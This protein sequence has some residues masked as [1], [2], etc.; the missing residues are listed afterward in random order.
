MK[1]HAKKTTITLVRPAQPEPRQRQDSTEKASISQCKPEPGQYQDS[2]EFAS[3][4]LAEAEPTALATPAPAKK[5]ARLIISQAAQTIAAQLREDRPMVHAQ[6]QRIINTVGKDRAQ[7]L[8]SQA[9]EI[10]SH[11][12]MQVC[13]GSRRRTVGGIFFYLCREVAGLKRSTWQPR[14]G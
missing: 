4:A 6:V 1:R 12:G 5:P 7:R 14:Q 8:A 13:D 10:E 9:T 2:T 11:G 3:I